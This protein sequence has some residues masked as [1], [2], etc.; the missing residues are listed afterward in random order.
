MNIG[1]RFKTHQCEDVVFY[2]IYIGKQI[3]SKAQFRAGAV[4]DKQS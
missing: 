2:F 4:A 3:N 1:D